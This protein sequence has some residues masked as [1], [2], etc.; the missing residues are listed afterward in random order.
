MVNIEDFRK[1]D[2][3]TGKV[4]SVDDIK[5]SGRLYVMNVDVGGRS[6]QIV[7]GLKKYYRKEELERKNVIVITNLEPA[8][9]MGVRSE[10]MLLAAQDGDKVTALVPD[11]DVK[12][13][14]RVT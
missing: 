11:K 8:T 7:A 6:I 9:I 10:G 14:S 12:E 13:G 3:R 4:T 1:F 2:I 5:G